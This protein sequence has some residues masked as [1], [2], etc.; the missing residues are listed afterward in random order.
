M[1]VPVAGG[2]FS[3]TMGD[4]EI[5][6][7][8]ISKRRVD[9]AGEALRKKDLSEAD[10]AVLDA[11]RGAHTYVIN[12]FQALLRNRAKGQKIEVAQRLKRRA[13]IVDKI[14]NREKEMDLS[15]MDDIAG[16][17]LI[18]G[19]MEHLYEFRKQ[20]HGARFNHKRKNEADRYDYIKKPKELGYRAV[21]DIYAYKNNTKSGSLFN[22]LHIE[23]QY[24]TQAQQAWA[25]AVEL[26][27]QLTKYEPKFNRNADKHVAL[28]KIASE[29]IARVH[30]DKRSCHPDLKEKEL[31]ERLED[32]EEEARAIDFLRRL[33]MYKW[34]DETARSKNVI[35]QLKKDSDLKVH[36]YDTELEAS[37][38]LFE[39]EKANPDDDIV[40][41]GADTVADVMSSFRNYFKDAG[42]FLILLRSGCISLA[43]KDV[44]V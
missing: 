43:G 36:S 35:L 29:I 32:L 17:R 14:V 5:K 1:A 39:L 40:L 38:A 15:R 7:P 3:E 16:C 11:W 26:I 44:E 22:G 21:H 18:F 2:L 27:T 12:T 42:Q 13:T 37:A 41:V 20:V 33:Q 19:S 8:W 31:V 24:R 23:I 34:I 30:E 28:F 4:D 10:A 6:R 9:A 25:T